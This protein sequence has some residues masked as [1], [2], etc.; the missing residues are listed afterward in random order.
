[1]EPV[2][3]SSSH[4]CKL[5]IF[6]LT[7]VHL[8]IVVEMRSTASLDCPAS[9]TC[10]YSGHI[11]CKQAFL[12][13]IPHIAPTFHPIQLYQLNS[14]RIR[15][16][17]D[18]AFTN[19][20][21]LIV[22]QLSHNAISVIKPLAFKGLLHLLYLHLDYNR[23]PDI[24]S[25]HNL[26]SLKKLYLK[27]NQISTISTDN[28]HSGNIR[29]LLR[30]DLSSNHFR[31]LSNLS[32]SAR[33]VIVQKGGLKVFDLQ[34]ARFASV[35]QEV[36]VNDNFIH[37]LPDLRNMTSLQSLTMINNPVFKIKSAFPVTLTLL[38]L[39]RSSV[40]RFPP[41][42]I[43]SS[44]KFLNLDE[45]R[46]QYL[47][48]IVE[49][50]SDALLERLHLSKNLMTDGTLTSVMNLL[51]FL[52]ISYNQLSGSFVYDFSKLPHLQCLKLRGNSVTELTVVCNESNTHS[53][54]WNCSCR[55]SNL[56]ILDVCENDITD[57]A[58]L[59]Y[60]PN[61]K[62]L[63]ACNNK[64]MT[65]DHMCMGYDLKYLTQIH[66]Q[67]NRLTNL[68]C[69][70]NL[71]SLDFLDVS[72]NR[73]NRIDASALWESPNL[74]TLY[75]DG[76]ELTKFP[77][78][79][80]G[81]SIQNIQLSRNN[82]G[83]VS[84]VNLQAYPKLESLDLSENG[85][86]TLHI[87]SGFSLKYLFLSGNQLEMTEKLSLENM[88]SLEMLNLSNNQFARFDKKIYEDKYHYNAKHF[89]VD[90]SGNCLSEGLP[91]IVPSPK[92]QK[93]LS[94]RYLRARSNKIRNL[95]LFFFDVFNGDVD[96]SRN[97]LYAILDKQCSNNYC[98]TRQS[99][100][101]SNNNLY[102]IS[103][104]VFED[105]PCIGIL[106]VSS[107]PISDSLWIYKFP[108]L[109]ALDVSF[110]N[111]ALKTPLANKSLSILKMN[112][113]ESKDSYYTDVFTWKEDANIH[114]DLS[115]QRNNIVSF[116]TL[117]SRYLNS[118]DA[119]YNQIRMMTNSSLHSLWSLGKLVLHHN[120]ITVIPTHCFASCPHVSHIDLSKNIIQ[121]ISESAFDG[122]SGA[123]I[124][125]ADNHLVWVS[126]ASLPSFSHSLDLSRNPWHCD[127]E[128][129]DLRQW[130]IHSNL[131]TV[132]CLT[133]PH[134]S[135]RNLVD[136]DTGDLDSL[137]EET[138]DVFCGSMDTKYPDLSNLSQTGQLT[139]VND[140]WNKAFK[141]LGN[142]FLS[143]I[144]ILIYCA[145]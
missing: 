50:M 67:G 19:M 20:S 61:L 79:S 143:V 127:Q 62:L 75:L 5:F 112:G 145:A 2:F 83:N 40:S 80:S 70:N 110:T 60:F 139:C 45:N 105:C 65:F 36:N 114:F 17:E 98:V 35:F 15:R 64:L 103:S 74:M 120:R 131:G 133:P 56:I 59:S 28:L 49:S 51:K 9:C 14:N 53:V 68:E 111:I 113:M 47:R 88:L 31:G 22:L 140:S 4:L 97:L 142:P 122:L 116:P 136:L 91:F 119:S 123:F 109:G 132:E 55:Y 95:P 41:N 39:E 32:V 93:N 66:L 84:S 34:N 37:S 78:L 99:I 30:L 102:Y 23:I 76:N 96:L 44:L 25:I 92:A 71:P 108:R 48:D 144:L 129:E 87:T 128:L 118:L 10:A 6:G 101:M 16:I 73:I 72:G 24:S 18:E 69:F 63:Y 54:E 124:N 26:P 12:T 21:S 7:V 27:Y 104:T 1:M 125:L 135:G 126:P 89:V 90:V 43:R 86:K 134:L 42:I 29:K 94:G 46:V 11:N 115:I 100:D 33:K 77:L 58:F 137:Q 121:F 82:L 13:D 141:Q 85:L 8:F 138:S 107:N 3:V 57:L 52:D 38:T 130:L 81:Y 106:N 117:T